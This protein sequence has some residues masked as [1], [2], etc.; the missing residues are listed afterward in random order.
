MK[1]VNLNLENYKQLTT[2]DGVTVIDA[3]ASWCGPCQMFAPVYEKVSEQYPQHSFAKMN[4]QQETELRD[5][6]EIEYIPTL[7]IYKNGQLIYKEAGS[8]PEDILQQ[9]IEHAEKFVPEQSVQ[10]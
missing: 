8:P 9:L 3:W 6:L 1:T 7:L 2:Q 10:N 4:V 5:K